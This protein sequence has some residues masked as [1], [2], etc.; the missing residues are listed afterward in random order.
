MQQGGKPVFVEA[1]V[2]GAA[3]ERFNVGV[4][5]WLARFALI[6]KATPVLALADPG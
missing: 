3:I 1:F 2:A 4:L 6:K 5:V